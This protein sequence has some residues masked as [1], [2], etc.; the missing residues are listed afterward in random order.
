MPEPRA[1]PGIAVV[2]DKLYAIG[3]LSNDGDALSS[4]EVFDPVA[5]SWI[6][7]PDMAECRISFGTATVLGKFM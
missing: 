3:G 1:D 2:N 4:V 7:L 6:Q 5:G